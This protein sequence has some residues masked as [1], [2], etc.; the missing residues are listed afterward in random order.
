MVPSALARADQA[1]Q[2][3]TARGS[4]NS[5]AEAARK[6]SADAKK[7]AAAA[8]KAAAAATKAAA[9]AKKASA[10]AKKAAAAAD[11][12]SGLDGAAAGAAGQGE[13]G[14]DAHA[15]HARPA[16]FGLVSG[17]NFL[18][19]ATGLGNPTRDDQ[20]PQDAVVVG[21]RVGYDLY[22]LA[23]RSVL[24]PRLTAEVETHLS[25]SVVEGSDMD[26][27]NPVRVR[28]LWAPVLSYRAHLMV[29]AFNGWPLQPFV[30]AGGGGQT[31]AS[32]ASSLTALDT[33]GTLHWGGGLRLVYRA[34]SL[35]FD[36]R[37]V[38]SKGTDSSRTTNHE[39]HLGIGIHFGGGCH[40][41]AAPVTTTPPSDEDPDPD[42]DGIL[43]EDEC[44][45]E[46]EDFDEFEDDDGCPD[47]DNDHDRILDSVDKCPDTAENYNGIEDTD[48]CPEED[49]DGDGLVG[50]SDLCPD[51]PEDKDTFQDEDGCPD[52]DNDGD[53]IPDA[54]DS[55]PMDAET[56]NKF[57]DADGC[58]D[59]VP[60]ALAKFSGVIKGIEFQTGKARIRLKSYAILNEVVKVLK[61]NP[62]VRIEIQ[63]H[64]DSVGR[65]ARNLALSEARANSVL[66]F[67]TV[68]GIDP[69]RLAAKGYGETR[70]IASNRSRAGR[71]KNRRVQFER[72]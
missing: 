56:F 53:G 69:T 72:Q 55:C 70:P 14:A 20:I 22:T 57:Q 52:P 6:A 28:D 68:N 10:N 1:K 35:R 2:P 33:D 16:Y 30:L 41:V 51:E 23:P 9:A 49:P 26:E 47:V 65:D 21:L 44:P 39:L 19:P 58:P 59:E 24:S 13:T 4:V 34:A 25:F 61:D 42:R 3:S 63:G 31:L 71:A 64:T 11:R 62:G 37:Q 60:D 7:A 5:A 50:K 36:Y 43:E 54:G 38:F 45:T 46:A 48:G 12:A 32:N 40:C 17:G 29:S 15:A 8:K 67:L 18:D 66:N 27:M